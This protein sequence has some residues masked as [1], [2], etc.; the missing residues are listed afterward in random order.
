MGNIKTRT[1]ILIL[2]V[3]LVLTFTSCGLTVPRPEIKEGEFDLSV[4]YELNGEQKTL[5]AVYICEYDGVSWSIEGGDF[6]RDWAD[7]TEG[8]YEGDD[9]SAIIGKT[10]D[11]GDIC[12][13]FGVYPEYFM[14]D[15]TGDR[16]VPEP[17]LY[18]AYPEDEDG[19][20]RHIGDAAV[21]E[22]EYGAKILSYKYEKPIDNSY[23]LLK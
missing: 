18:I 23:G 14:G 8:Q 10:E 22:E 4:T 1:I 12:L 6:S 21:I 17:S 9:Y 7:R 15:S 13:F 16:G 11:G 20:M 5:T 19:G 2:T 3:A